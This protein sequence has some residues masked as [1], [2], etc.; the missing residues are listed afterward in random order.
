MLHHDVKL[1]IDNTHTSVYVRVRG[2]E[3]GAVSSLAPK[4]GPL[5]L[6]RTC[7]ALA[8]IA[9]PPSCALGPEEDR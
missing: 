5:G 9:A 4:V 3:V 6:V 7:L 1:L 8:D 2:G